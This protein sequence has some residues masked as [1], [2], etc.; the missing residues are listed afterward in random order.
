MGP[1]LWK[2]HGGFWQRAV[3]DEAERLKPCMCFLSAAGGVWL[4]ITVAVC[5][6]TKTPK[7]RVL[8]QP[9]TAPS[10]DHG[11]EIP[12]KMKGADFFIS[13]RGPLGNA[14]RLLC[15]GDGGAREGLLK[16]QLRFRHPL[17]GH[18]G[19]RM[20]PVPGW[21]GR[22]MAS[23]ESEKT[24]TGK[25]AGSQCWAIGW[26]RALLI[27][28][29]RTGNFK[30]ADPL[31][32]ALGWAA[33]LRLVK[34]GLLKSSQG[35]QLLSRLEESAPRA[36]QLGNP[37]ALLSFSASRKR[38]DCV[39]ILTAGQYLPKPGPETEDRFSITAHT[40]D[41]HMAFLSLQ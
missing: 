37:N 14:R 19:C 7:R 23:W 34:I 27:P 3:G 16:R 15:C 26:M 21:C 22:G 28:L 25:R 8:A 36:A 38:Q 17:Y 31:L 4:S 10:N 11:N 41:V 18:G 2:V 32:N 6:D 5:S 40:R 20:L 9:F 24:V 39:I 1:D 13:R 29:D 12:V 33:R 35:P 30:R